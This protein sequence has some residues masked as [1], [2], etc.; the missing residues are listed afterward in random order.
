[1][2]QDY[3]LFIPL[4]S[5][6]D[7]I[8]ASF[9]TDMS[10]RTI[11]AITPVIT[12]GLTLSF[13]TYGLLIIKG[14]ID[15]AISDFLMRSVRI[16]II[17]GIA[18]AGGLYQSDIADTI[19]TLPDELAASL[20]KD[21]DNAGVSSAIDKATGEG[22]HLAGEAFSKA[23]FFKADG[24]LYFIYGV[25]ILLTTSVFVAIG[26]AI[27]LLTKLILAV[28]IGLGPLFIISL[29][30]QPTSRYFELWVTQIVNYILL[31]VLFTALFSL[32]LSIYS[33]YVSDM[34]LDGEQNV[35]GSL[36]GVIVL[37]IAMIVVLIQLPGIAFALSGG[38]SLSYRRVGTIPGSLTNSF[39][40]AVIL[41]DKYTRGT[42]APDSNNGGVASGNKN[43][44]AG[45]G[46]S[47][48]YGYYKG[49]IGKNVVGKAS[50]QQ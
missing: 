16:I 22:F 26:G 12:A 34:K 28:L 45:K 14:A 44:Y 7:T 47:S 18:L 13:V 1:M 17:T 6:I 42:N 39:K 31:A 37:S 48:T 36:G 29:L 46:Q 38:I 25:V 9:I 15:L 50:H 27:L 24:T 32:M 4:F 10:E 5:K 33:G 43:S 23:S 41:M 20:I 35:S 30:W 8:T 11:V 49:N 19:R 3:Q 21:A 40:R 2:A